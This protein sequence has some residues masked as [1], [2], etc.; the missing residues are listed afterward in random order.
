MC[1]TH[2][3]RSGSISQ[4]LTCCSVQRYGF[5]HLVDPLHFLRRL[6]AQLCIRCKGC[7]CFP[8]NTWLVWVHGFRVLPNRKGVVK[9][10]RALLQVKHTTLCTIDVH[11]K[12]YLNNTRAMLESVAHISQSLWPSS[13]TNSAHISSQFAHCL[14]R[15]PL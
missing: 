7:H 8:V 9:A 13:I 3:F 5:Q 4:E 10:Q 6:L 1:C 11:P 15:S 12:L 14:M 2:H